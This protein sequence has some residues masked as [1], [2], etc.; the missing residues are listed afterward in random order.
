MPTATEEELKNIIPPEYR[1]FL[2]V[3]E[4]RGAG[5]NTTDDVR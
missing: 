1:D 4:P 3:F 5:A 2:D